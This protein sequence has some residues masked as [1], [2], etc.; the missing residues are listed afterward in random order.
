MV[1]DMTGAQGVFEESSK[2]N[3][4]GAQLV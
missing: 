4:S 1:W 2:G 3:N